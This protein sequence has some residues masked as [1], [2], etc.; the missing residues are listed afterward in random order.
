MQ[1]IHCTRC[2]RFVDLLK[3]MYEGW[4]IAIDGRKNLYDVRCCDCAAKEYPI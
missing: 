4:N 3:A 1:L 2:L